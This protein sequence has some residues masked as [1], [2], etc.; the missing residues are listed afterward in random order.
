MNTI[1]KT[2]KIIALKEGF[3]INHTAEECKLLVVLLH[4]YGSS[5]DDLISLVPYLKEDL[6]CACWFAPNGIEKMQDF[7]YAWFSYVPNNLERMQQGI[8]NARKGTFDLIDK[9]C[10]SLGLSRQQVCIIGFSQGGMVAI[11]L[12]LSSKIPLACAISFSGAF[13]PYKEKVLVHTQTPLCLIHGKEDEVVPFSHLKVSV[14]QLEILGCK[15]ESHEI[16]HL[17]HSIDLKG[18]NIAKDFL[19]QNVK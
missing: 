19:L 1:K 11:D 2:S 10:D 15:V 7:G 13:V 16:E 18:L 3:E 6:P 17:A 12:A 9:K 5:G 14:N 8:V 4:G